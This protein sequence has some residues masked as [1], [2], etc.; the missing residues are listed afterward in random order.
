V[1][2]AIALWQNAT[3]PTTADSAHDTAKDLKPDGSVGRS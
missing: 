1:E 3:P 2:P